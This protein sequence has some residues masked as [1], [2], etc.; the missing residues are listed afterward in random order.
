MRLYLTNLASDVSGFKLALVD[1]RN[2]SATATV[3][4]AV[5]TLAVGSH[6]STAQ[7]T[8]NSMTLTAGGSTAAKWITKPFKT[9]FTIP[10]NRLTVNYWAHTTTG[11][12]RH[13]APW[14]KM[15]T[16]SAAN[17]VRAAFVSY[18]AQ[19]LKAATVTHLTNAPH[20]IGNVQALSP[21]TM[22]ATTYQTSAIAATAVAA[23]ERIAIIGKAVNA[24]KLGTASMTQVATSNLTLDFDGNADGK[25]G[26]TYIVI[27]SGNSASLQPTITKRQINNTSTQVT[28]PGL[29]KGF[30]NNLILQIDAAVGTAE[31]TKDCTLQSFYNELI[32]ERDNN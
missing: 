30:Y 24:V 20:L 11:L 2:P 5:T 32:A 28:A 10:A 22:I 12:S 6:A 25:D 23:G 21:V 1:E 26:D 7:G 9:A 3:A 31:F 19:S 17:T 27:P 14:F 29:G 15:A 16:V 18:N 4:T 8:T 13:C